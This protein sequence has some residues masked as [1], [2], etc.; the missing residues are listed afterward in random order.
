MINFTFHEI[1][2]KVDIFWYTEKNYIYIETKTT[3]DF[4]FITKHFTV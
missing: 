4:D 3:F 1:W 2:V